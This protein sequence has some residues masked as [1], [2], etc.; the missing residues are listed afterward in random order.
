MPLAPKDL[1]NLQSLVQIVASLRGPGGCPWDQEQTH[2]TLAR[3]AVEE[4]HELAEALE[5]KQDE[6]MKEELGDVLFQVILHAQLAQ[7]RKAFDLNDVIEAL[8]SKLVRRHPHVFSDQ[9]VSGKDEVIANWEVLKK[10]EKA[11]TDP[12][13]DLNVPAGLP[14][15][16]R[17]AKIGFRTEKLKFDWENAEQVREK[18]REEFAELE[19]ALDLESDEEIRHELGDVF[20]SLAQLARHLDLDPEQIG[21]EANRR[22][23]GRFRVMMQLRD[24]KSLVWEAMTLEDK[25]HLWQEAKKKIKLEKEKK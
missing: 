14:A 24:E 2:E 17:A 25:E 3:Y 21:R 19:E 11:A 23:E 12:F 9:Q 1:R 18:V 13:F 7:E 4:A 16:Q 20:F 10:Q 5:S 6:W 22:F 8:A 15:L